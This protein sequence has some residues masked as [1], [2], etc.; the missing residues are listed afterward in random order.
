MSFIVQ[1]GSKQY[2]IESGQSFA[3]DHLKEKKEGDTFE[4]PVILGIGAD[5]GKASVKVKVKGHAKAKKIRVV[6]YKAKS[7]YHRQYGFRAMQTVLTVVDEA[8]PKKET[9][10]KKTP[11]KTEK[12]KATKKVTSKKTEL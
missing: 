7:N 11:E 3:V 9:V 1:T 4:L 12:P 10:A 6:K 2:I 5:E 8:A